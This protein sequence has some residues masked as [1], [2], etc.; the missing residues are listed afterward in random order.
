MEEARGR[1]CEIPG[2]ICNADRWWNTREL[3]TVSAKR[4][5]DDWFAPSHGL[6]HL[7]PHA[8]A[9]PDGRHGYFRFSKASTK[10]GNVAGDFDVSALSECPHSLGRIG[11]DN[12]QPNA[13][14]H[15]SEERHDLVSQPEGGI[16][17]R[18]MRKCANEHDQSLPLG[19]ITVHQC[20]KIIAERVDLQLLLESA[21]QSQC[22]CRIT[23]GEDLDT[24][25][26][27]PTSELVGNPLPLFDTITESCNQANSTKRAKFVPV[28]G[29]CGIPNVRLRKYDWEIFGVV[30][31]CHGVIGEQNGVEYLL[32][33]DRIDQA[34]HGRIAK[35]KGAERVLACC[36]SQQPVQK[37]DRQIA[38]RAG[39]LN[40]PTMHADCPKRL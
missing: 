8:A 24:G 34:L 32:G 22:F 13:W 12:F 10:F 29:R 26:S 20:W 27:A 25:C 35:P 18:A 17:V 36:P 1:S 9:G 7:L 37:P 16:H 38:R 33:K 39:S 3:Q 31:R 28:S 11:S 6:E 15:L 21:I 30:V 19:A 14:S 40:S 4:R 5:G 2:R 23:G